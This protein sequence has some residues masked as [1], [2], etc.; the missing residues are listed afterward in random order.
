MMG[1]EDFSWNAMRRFL[2]Q[3]G[4]INSI[5][6]FDANMV[7]QKMRNQVNKLIQSKPM[8]FEQQNIRNIS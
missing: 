6:H 3:P 4:V 8:S 1:Q 2:G 7:T 5:L